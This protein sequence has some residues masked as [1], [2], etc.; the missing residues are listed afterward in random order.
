[1]IASRNDLT[2]AKTLLDNLDQVT[3]ACATLSPQKGGYVTFSLPQHPNLS[4]IQ[5]DVA[6]AMVVLRQ[7]H[8]KLVGQLADLG[9]TTL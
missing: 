9:V 4:G 6:D 8:D 3:S 2:A 1:M 7:L 5:V